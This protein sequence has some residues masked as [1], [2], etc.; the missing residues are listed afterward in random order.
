VKVGEE[1]ISGN[2]CIIQFE[3]LKSVYFPNAED[4]DMKQNFASFAYGCEKW[5]LGEEPK[6]QGFIKKI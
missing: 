3:N 1:Y 5:F 2:V 4:Q 6:L